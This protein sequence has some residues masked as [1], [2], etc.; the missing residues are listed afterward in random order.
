MMDWIGAFAVAMS[1][2]SVWKYTEYRVRKQRLVKR[3]K[4]VC[5]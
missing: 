1:I 4:E 3:L 5:R 2:V